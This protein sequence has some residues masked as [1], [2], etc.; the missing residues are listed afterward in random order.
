MVKKGKEK[1]APDPRQVVVGRW[2]GVPTDFFNAATDGR[3]YLARISMVHTRPRRTACGCGL[4][5]RQAGYGDKSYAPLKTVEKWIIS[6]AEK[7]RVEWYEDPE[8]S[9]DEDEDEQQAAAAVRRDRERR[10]DDS[11]LHGSV[12]NGKWTPTAPKAA[13]HPID[14]L[15]W[16]KASSGVASHKPSAWCAADSCALDAREGADLPTQSQIYESVCTDRITRLVPRE[17]LNPLPPLFRESG[18]GSP[19]RPQ[20]PCRPP[21]AGPAPP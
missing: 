18:T 4:R 5:K 7:D 13:P 3:R 6:D 2:L 9:S 19:T 11:Q 10:S 20:C 1:A 16:H 8:P 14:K 17:L 12:K 21:V 15:T